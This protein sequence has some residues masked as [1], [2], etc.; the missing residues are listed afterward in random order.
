[1]R[2]ESTGGLERRSGVTAL[3]AVKER[4]RCKTRLAGALSDSARL[5]LVRSM[6]TRVLAAAFAAR[7]VQE[8][9]VV[10]PERD[11][12]PAEVRV[13]AD[14]GKSLNNALEQAHNV[15][16]ALGCREFLV[17]PADLPGISSADIDTLVRA[18]HAGGYAIAPDSSGTGTNALYFTSMQPLRFHFG[19]D[20]Y[21]LHL[22]QARAAGLDP[23]IVRLP[24]LAFDLDS[25]TDLELLGE[26]T[27]LTRLRA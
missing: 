21:S 5:E 18:G 20:S 2:T 12:I 25:P 27:W 13:L 3:I 8:V 1:V 9:V 15:L 19:P 14:T 22:Q 7:T 23:Q 26:Q 6:L 17:L 10:S 4:A 24:G 11:Q 16:G